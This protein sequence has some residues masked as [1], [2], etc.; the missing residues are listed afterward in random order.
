VREGRRRGT[1]A[2]ESLGMDSGL[3]SIH[4]GKDSAI[5]LGKRTT[6]SLRGTDSE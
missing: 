1:L 5:E 2:K 6:M 3:C 4:S